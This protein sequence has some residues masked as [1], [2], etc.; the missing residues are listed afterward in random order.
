MNELSEVV[1]LHKCLK[2]KSGWY[3]DFTCPDE[4]SFFKIIEKAKCG[5]EDKLSKMTFLS[6][7]R[8][9]LTWEKTEKTLP[10]N[11]WYYDSFL[12]WVVFELGGSVLNKEEKLLYD[13]VC[14]LTIKF[15]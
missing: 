15:I 3:I 11:S 6:L 4:Y 7:W 13:E 1:R 12:N 14:N 8:R 10:E 2:D 9:Y 5:A